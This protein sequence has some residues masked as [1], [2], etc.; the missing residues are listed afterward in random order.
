MPKYKIGEVLLV[1]VSDPD[2]GSVSYK[3]LVILDF[4]YGK[5]WRGGV[6]AYV[7]D[8]G[9]ERNFEDMDKIAICLGEM[10]KILY[11]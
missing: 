3:P 5:A 2:M 8:D 7:F 1:I 11:G 10:G 6:G 9:S 4:T